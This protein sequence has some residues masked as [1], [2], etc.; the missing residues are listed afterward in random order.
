MQTETQITIEWDEPLASGG[1]AIQGYI[2]Y[3]E[4]IEEPGFNQVYNG[5]NQSA[6][7]RFVLTYPSIKASKYYRV[8]VQAINCSLKSAGSTIKVTSGAEPVA[9]TNAP[10]VFSFDN[11]TSMTIR[12]EPPAYDGGF[13]ITSMKV[14]VDN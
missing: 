5:M 3:L 6:I 11:P 10:I 1:C 7:T 14:Y 2:G 4:D 12:W 8:R 13:P 9:L